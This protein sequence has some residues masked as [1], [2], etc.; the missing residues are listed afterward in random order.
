VDE[1]QMAELIAAKGLPKSFGQPKFGRLETLIFRK[2]MLENI[3]LEKWMRLRYRDRVIFGKGCKIDPKTFMLRGAGVVEFGE[4]VIIERGLHKV[5]FNLEPYSKVTIGANSW[6][7]TFT[8]DILFS[9][10]SGAEI[11]IGKNSWFSGC[12]FAAAKKI[13]MGEHTMIGNH[14]MIID[15]EYHQMENDAAIPTA[16]VTIGSHVFM[17][18]QV[19]VLKGVTIGDH[20]MFGTGALVISDIPDH[21]LAAGRPAKVIRKIGDR[22]RAW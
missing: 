9:C 19:S 2:L 11:V 1:K 18:S 12:Q 10:K 16:P 14:C 4:N 21:S 13:V 5:F 6:F 3:L 20:C 15:S 8:D 22:D 7:Q 17:P